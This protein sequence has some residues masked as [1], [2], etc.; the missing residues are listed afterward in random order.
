MIARRLLYLDSQRLSAYAWRQG[1]LQ[2]E[3]SFE[4][5][6]EDHARFIEYLRA[7]PRSEFRMLA[8]LGEEAH[9]TEVIPFLQGK[10]RA[11]LIARKLGQHFLG[12][13]L[14]TAITLGFEKTKRKNEKLLLIALTNPAP[15]APWLE[16]MQAA[17]AALAGLYTVA[18][19]GGRLLDRLGK[20]PRHALLLTC[21][22]HSI[23]ESYVADGHT[24]FSRLTPLSDSSIAGIAS[25][26]A[27]E[28]TKLHQYLVGKRHIRRSETVAVYVLAHPQAAV[29][30]RQACVD[31]PQLAFEIIDAHA[32]ARRIDLGTLPDDNRADLHFL[33]LVATSPPRQQLAPESC[34]H[35]YRIAQVRSGLLALGAVALVAG[36]LFAAR[37]FYAAYDLHRETQSLAASEGELNWRYREIAATFPQLAI[38]KDTL[39]RIT[40]RHAA[41]LRQQRLPDAAYRLVGRAMNEAPN[42]HLDALDW[43]LGEDRATTATARPAPALE[44]NSQAIVLRGNVRLG[45]ASTARQTLATFEHFVDLLRADRDN[46][47]TVLKQPLDIESSRALR[48]GDGDED[49]AQPRNFVV[50]I[51]RRL[52]P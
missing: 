22:D 39:R 27:A 24:L 2:P 35:D 32:A 4:N 34:R 41:L 33:H 46:E 21:Q 10:D 49:G 6:P 45:A 38:D 51:A 18:Q 16:C 11:A 13:P 9:E 31:T 12:T 23:R 3:G 20:T 15:V 7:R 1:R 42:I 26:F 37:Q 17:D 47:V 43:T 28:A 19:M 25:R 40:D 36:A 14:A 30:V 52:A 44:G 5:R 48:G 50:R 29:A 8:N